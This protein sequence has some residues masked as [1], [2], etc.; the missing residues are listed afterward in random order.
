[1][2]NQIFPRP[3]V[4][5]VLKKG[6]IEARLHMDNPDTAVRAK[7]EQVRKRYGGGFATPTFVIVDPKTGKMLQRH[8]GW[9]PK[10]ET[11]LNFL[12]GRQ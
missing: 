11:F 12:G 8:E 6:F 5:G 4:A 3:A 2:E 7:S 1:M 9:I 10:E